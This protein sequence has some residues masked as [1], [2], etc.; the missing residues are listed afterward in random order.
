M[1]IERVPIKIFENDLDASIT[2]AKRIAE[3]IRTKTA[4]GAAPVLGLATGNTPVKVYR[5][6]IRMHKEEAL[7]FSK[8]ITF[9][10]DEYWPITPSAVQSYHTW[11][12]ENFFKHINIDYNNIFIPSG[13]WPEEEIESR[14]GEY[15]EMISKHGGIDIQILGIGRSGHIGFNEPGSER[16]SRTRCVYLDKKTRM[17]ASSDFFGEEYVPLMAITMG[18]G[19]IMEAREICLMAF[20]EK[21]ASIIRSAAEE[22]ISPTIAASSLQDHPS[23]AFYLDTSASGALT[24][25]ATP[26]VYGSCD[27]DEKLQHHAV[28]WL[29]LKLG[30]AILKLTDED[31]TENGLLDLLRNSGGAYNLNIKVFKHLMDTITGWPAGKTDRKN[32]LIFSP[33][34]DD[35]VISMGGTMIRTVEQGHNTHVA[36]MTSGYLS[37]FDHLV[38]RHA[39]F[40][41]EFNEIFGISTDQTEQIEQHIDR[42]LNRKT[43]GQI[44]SPEVVEIKRL[45]RKTEAIDAAKFC[46]LEDE[47][48]H[49]LAMPFYNTGKVEKLPIGE[50]DINTVLTL[51]EKVNPDMIFAAGDMSDPHGTHRLCLDATLRA[52]GK[53]KNKSGRD[54]DIW[55]YR[56]AWQEWAPD[57]IDMAVPLSPDE[58]KRKRFAIFRHESQKDHAMFPGPSDTR[59]FWQRAEYRNKS[60]AETYD[61]LGLP[62]YHAIEAFVRAGDPGTRL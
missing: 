20:G 8:V 32:I 61:K 53:Y 36:Y 16:N 55:L 30:T 57:E 48:I 9:N 4:D 18:V 46:G 35:D 47:N 58:L 21:K 33:H 49:F 29:A 10:L 22:E 60:T 45:I 62:E 54:P 6:L 14:C 7:D 52:I 17:D 50:D 40:V 44:D 27:W 56:G 43:P 28:I 39:D 15:E 26:W 12:H 42:F 31:Y 34:P 11:M 24:R 59:E 19:T 38:R 37:V 51:L 41:R 3:V 5:E 1:H 13:E 25:S 2:V 23:A